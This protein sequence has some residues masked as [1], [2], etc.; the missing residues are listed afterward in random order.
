MSTI[1]KYVWLTTLYDISTLAGT[2]LGVALKSKILQGPL[3]PA[4]GVYHF[5]Q[6]EDW[7]TLTSKQYYT[8]LSLN[9]LCK[10][11]QWAQG[12]EQEFHRTWRNEIYDSFY[13][14]WLMN[15]GTCEEFILICFHHGFS[16]GWLGRCSSNPT[17]KN[18]ST[19]KQ[20]IALVNSQPGQI[21]WN[22]SL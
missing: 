14:C 22:T 1:K 15:A 9:L 18:L 4:Q 13:A 16:R 3:S 21:C 19:V 2:G 10:D 20:I 17:T 12:R 6:L 5:M 11:G 8:S 7:L